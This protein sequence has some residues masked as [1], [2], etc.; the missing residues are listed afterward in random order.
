M[1]RHEEHNIGTYISYLDLSN[2]S[3]HY[4]PRSRE[5]DRFAAACKYV[6]YV[7]GIMSGF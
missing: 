5:T 2:V 3:F 4:F 7:D 6:L 1:P